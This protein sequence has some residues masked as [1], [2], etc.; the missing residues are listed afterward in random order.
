MESR[1]LYTE[2]WTHNMIEK[3]P[4]PKGKSVKVTFSIPAE[5]VDSS[6]AVAGDFNEWSEKQNPMK[7]DKKKNAWTCSVTLKSGNSYRFRY[8]IDG[9][10]RNDAAADAYEANPYMGEDCVVRL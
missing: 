6:A 10:W 2:V 4:S 8:L 1:S 5:A 9:E 7:Y 3:K